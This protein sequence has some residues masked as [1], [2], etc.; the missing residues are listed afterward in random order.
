[1]VNKNTYSQLVDICKANELT[2]HWTKEQFDIDYKNSL[3]CNIPYS[4]KK[5]NV[6]LFGSWVR[7]KKGYGLCTECSIKSKTKSYTE[8]LTDFENAGFVLLWDENQFN[9]NYSSNSTYNIPY[10]CD[11]GNE[12]LTTVASVRRGR[13]CCSCLKER[14]KATCIEK[15]G[16]EH[17]MK[18]LETKEKFKATC[19]LKY[20]V[21]YPS[22]VL[23]V[24]ERVKAT[25]MEKFGVEYAFQAPEVIQK[26]KQTCL[27]IWGVEHASQ[28]LEIKQ[29][30]K[31]TCLANWNV[32]YTLQAPEIQ[33]RI[34]ETCLAN[35]GVEHPMQAPEIAEKVLK[36]SFRTKTYVLPSGDELL[37]QGYENFAL[38]ELLKTENV[39]EDDIV[40]AKSEVPEIW[41]TRDGK[42]HRYF[43][44]LFIP[45]QNLCIE[46]KSNYTVTC[47]VAMNKLKKQA[48]LDTGYKYELRVY[49]RHGNRQRGLE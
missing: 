43:I 26:I 7:L 9:I 24:R 5:C 44:D 49:D 29:K 10:I 16:V 46:V 40:T 22:Q 45:S 20:G 12:A 48:T 42:R 34:K 14:K 8:V 32:E 27:E 19:M 17:Q 6:K 3:T 35:W 28:A 31:E 11:C 47:D 38:D 30:V 4:C 33:E 1:M 36:S 15:Y 13:K 2:I 25:C 21:E 39:A 18:A 23:E 41:Y 37:Y